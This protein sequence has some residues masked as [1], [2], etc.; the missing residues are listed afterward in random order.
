MFKSLVSIAGFFSTVIATQLYVSSY[1]G[2]ITTL[3][4]HQI[5][6]KNKF[7]LTTLAVD[8]TAP[9]NTSFLLFDKDRDVIYCTEEGFDVPNGFVSSYKTSSKG[10]LK[11]ISRIPTIIGDVHQA[12]Y[13][14]G[15]SLAV[16][17]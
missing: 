12:L 16:A 3:D 8:H 14:G 11:Q 9:Q 2:T 6:G 7:E 17:H 1:I 13:N 10:A 5:G 15:K 4:L